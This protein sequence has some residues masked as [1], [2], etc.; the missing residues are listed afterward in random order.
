MWP[1]GKVNVFKVGQFVCG[2]VLLLGGSVAIEVYTTPENEQ[3][4]PAP[5]PRADV[6][7]VLPSGAWLMKDGSIQASKRPD[8]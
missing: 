8:R 1:R 2:F 4:E 5:P 7:T 6:A 3:A